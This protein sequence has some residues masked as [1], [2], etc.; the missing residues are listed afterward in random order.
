MGFT[1]VG[2]VALQQIKEVGKGTGRLPIGD[3]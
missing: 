1:H 3:E 2:A